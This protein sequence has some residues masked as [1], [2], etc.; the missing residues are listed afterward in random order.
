MCHVS[1]LIHLWE[2]LTLTGTTDLYPLCMLHNQSQCNNMAV[3]NQMEGPMLLGE[4]FFRLLLRSRIT[5]GNH[6]TGFGMGNTNFGMNSRNPL[7]DMHVMYNLSNLFVGLTCFKSDNPT[8]V[9]ILLS[10]EPKRFIYAL[11]TSHSS[12]DFL[13]DVP[14][15]T[16]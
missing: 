4:I 6:P 7:C 9:D 10:S 15:E 5:A 14:T 12:S 13:N 16:P 8:P 3:I 2:I 1:S 11:N